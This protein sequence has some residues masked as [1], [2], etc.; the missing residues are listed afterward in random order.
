MSGAKLK[1]AEK[2]NSADQR[3]L[4]AEFMGLYEASGWKQ[5]RCAEELNVT[6]GYVSKI[7]NGGAVV[8]EALISHF[9]MKLAARNPTALRGA[10]SGEH[11]AEPGVHLRVISSYDSHGGKPKAD[12][13]QAL[14]EKFEKLVKT[15]PEAALSLKEAI[16]Y[17]SDGKK[18]KKGK[19]D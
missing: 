18:K 12:D 5:V 4:R 3:R 19:G 15:D 6:Q 7:L 13:V 1:E 8:E 9:K 11:S 16:A 17:L 10:E 2:L 14:R